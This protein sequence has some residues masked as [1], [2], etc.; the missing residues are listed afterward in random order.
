[1]AHMAAL[2]WK[3]DSSR[4]TSGSASLRV[5]EFRLCPDWKSQYLLK[6][7]KKRKGRTAGHYSCRTSLVC[8]CLNQRYTKH[9]ASITHSRWNVDWS[10][11]LVSSSAR[12][13]SGKQGLDLTFL[14]L[15]TLLTFQL[16][17]KIW[18]TCVSLQESYSQSEAERTVRATEAHFTRDSTFRSLWKD[19]RVWEASVCTYT[20]VRLAVFSGGKYVCLHLLTWPSC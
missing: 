1:M 15:L 4:G 20:T 3:A 12:H 18:L 17:A 19:R 13:V 11:W 16:P 5:W 8:K 2:S 6:S 7:S 14:T 10:E 9:S